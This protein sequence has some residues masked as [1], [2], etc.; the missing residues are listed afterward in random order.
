MD[1][2]GRDAWDE[3]Y[4]SAPSL[5]TARPNAALVEFA[6]ALPPGRA[7]DLG[8]GEGRNSVWL[9]TRG[10]QVT[11]LDVSQVALGRAAERAEA[12]GVQLRCAVEDWREHELAQDSLELVVVSFMHPD[13]DQRPTMFERAARALVPGGHLFV[14]GVHARDHGRR[15]PPD[16]DRLHTPE[17][18]RDALQERFEVLRCDTV[19]YERELKGELQVVTDVVGIGRRPAP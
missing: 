12:A 4:E 1:A 5:W 6:S 2:D 9:A 10:W 14:T 3:R 15:G 11:A 17:R 18:L 19:S 13:R 7:L 16:A 8:A